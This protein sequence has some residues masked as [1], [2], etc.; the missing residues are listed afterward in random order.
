MLWKR[1]KEEWPNF[2]DQDQ[3]SFLYQFISWCF[4]NTDN[5]VIKFIREHHFPVFFGAENQ[6]LSHQC[7]YMQP[8]ESSIE[9]IMLE[10]IE[11]LEFPANEK[12]FK[13]RLKDMVQYS[14]GYYHKYWHNYMLAYVR[15]ALIMS[16]TRAEF[17]AKNLTKQEATNK[18]LGA[19]VTKEEIESLLSKDYV[20]TSVRWTFPSQRD[21]LNYYEENK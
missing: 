13:S 8:I 2:I 4:S 7:K 6:Y 10:V 12:E 21:M 15:I 17:F 5:P 11:V 16:S 18:L 20:P 3:P 1:Y 19:G 9:G 14:I